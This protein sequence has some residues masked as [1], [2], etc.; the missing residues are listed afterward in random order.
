MAETQRENLNQTVANFHAKESSVRVKV[1]G[2]SGRFEAGRS[3]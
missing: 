2:L 1:A 3:C